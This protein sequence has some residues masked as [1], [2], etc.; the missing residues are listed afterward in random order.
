MED[1]IVTKYWMMGVIVVML[2]YA[3]SYF[4]FSNKGSDKSTDKPV[5]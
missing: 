5:R 3:I 1:V 2:I 4:V